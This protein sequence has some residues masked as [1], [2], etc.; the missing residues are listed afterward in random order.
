MPYSI[1]YID[2]EGGV[3][4]TYSGIVTN[5]DISNSLEER[6]SSRKR[7]KAYRYAITNCL[8]IESYDVTTKGMIYAASTASKVHKI[9]KNIVAINIM[10]SDLE[11]GMARIW[12]AHVS[13]TNWQVMTVRTMEEA[14][15]FLK[16]KLNN[17]V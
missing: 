6:L 8:N 5:D 13:H 1:D 15:C 14:Y 2:D 11:F 7:V 3:I 9:N 17:F 16:E 12:E 10:P 4:V